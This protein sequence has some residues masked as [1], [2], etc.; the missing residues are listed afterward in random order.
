MC[1]LRGAVFTRAL[2]LALVVG[3]WPSYGQGPPRLPSSFPRSDVSG[4][5]RSSV[6]LTDSTPR[7]R[8]YWV[9]G[10]AIG[11]VGGLVLAQ[12]VNALA[13]EG[14]CG[15]DQRVFVMV[16]GGFVIGALVGGGIEKQS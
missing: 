6:S 9:E 4:P 10:G 14:S 1:S 15:G 5:P 11:A 7:K 16:V 3:A 12:L 13:C 8:T 2:P